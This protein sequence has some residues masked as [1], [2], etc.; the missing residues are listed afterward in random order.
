MKAFRLENVKSFLDTG[1]INIKPINIFVGRNSSGKSSIIRFPVM[2]SQTIK[3]DVIAPF[4]LFG[5]EI[6]YGSF[7]DVVHNHNGEYLKFSFKFDKQEIRGNFVPYTRLNP[8]SRSMLMKFVGVLKDDLELKVEVRKINKRIIVKEFSLNINEDHFFNIS[9]N[10]NG[11]NIMSI[12]KVCNIVN[13]EFTI[14]HLEEEFEL[15]TKIQFDRF[16]PEIDTFSETFLKELVNS[17]GLNKI[18]DN[19]EIIEQFLEYI[20]EYNLNKISSLVEK[21][22]ISQENE[23]VIINTYKIYLTIKIIQALINSMFRLTK[24]FANSLSYIGPFRTDPERIYRESES[25]FIDVGKNG[26]NASMILRQAQQGDTNLLEKVSNWLE[27]SM[28]YRIEV[29]EIDNSNLFK[30]MVTSKESLVSHNIMDVGYGISQVLPILTQLYYENSTDDE[31]MRNVYRISGKKKNFVI[32]QPELHLHP[33]A[34]AALA[35]LFVEKATNKGNTIFIET[36]SEHLIRKLQ[37]LIADKN[38]KI[39]SDDIAIYYVDKSIGGD[40]FIKEIKLN[41]KGQFLDEWPTGFFD[42]SFE[43]SSELLRIQMNEGTGYEI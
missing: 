8:F 2:L 14:E 43:L 6:D 37:I 20:H 7:E 10:V 24:K 18:V 25:S 35:D 21:H 11:K 28:G 13:E 15:K 42:K 33:A 30:I 26:E 12:R 41:E 3:E 40:S 19:E 22:S 27:K 36:H 4:L 31:L 16:I 39:N 29:E 34:Q 32:E 5:K 17:T 9:R 23:K 1:D 38:V